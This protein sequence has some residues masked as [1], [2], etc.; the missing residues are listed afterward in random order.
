[1]NDEYRICKNKELPAINRVHKTTDISLYDLDKLDYS[2]PKIH[3]ILPIRLSLSEWA[4]TVNQALSVYKGNNIVLDDINIYTN[5][6]KL[7]K[8]LSNLPESVENIFMVYKNIERIFNFPLF[9]RVNK[10]RLHRLLHGVSYCKETDKINE[11]KELI[12]NKEQQLRNSGEEYIEF[13]LK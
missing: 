13:N 11:Y 10:I 2:T 12:I 9:D 8:E 6:A 7:P 1:M 5:V 3:R 4:K